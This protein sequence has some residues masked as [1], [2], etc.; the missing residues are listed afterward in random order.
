M[1]MALCHVIYVAARPMGG[2][3]FAN[4]IG[5][6]GQDRGNARNTTGLKTAGGGHRSSLFMLR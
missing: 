5:R 2:G 4:W 6:Q 1:N 3:G